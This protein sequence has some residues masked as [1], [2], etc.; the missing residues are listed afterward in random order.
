VV[1]TVVAAT[2]FDPLTTVLV[3]TG[4]VGAATAGT[5]WA[6]ARHSTRFELIAD[7]NATPSRREC[8]ASSTRRFTLRP[9]PKCFDLLDLAALWLVTLERGTALVLT[10]VAR[11]GSFSLR[12]ATTSE[13]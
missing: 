9:I 2:H 8:W 11:W 12:Q 6:G 1:L 3:L 13:V 10:R 5:P 7:L 4:V